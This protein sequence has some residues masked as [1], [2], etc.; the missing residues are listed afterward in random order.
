MERLYIE[1]SKYAAL[2]QNGAFK[3]ELKGSK[4]WENLMA[5]FAGESQ[6]HS[7][8]KYFAAKAKKDGY[9]QIAAIFDETA[10]NEIQHAKIWYKLLNGE[11]GETQGNL[12]LAADGE[13]YEWTDMYTEFAK[14]AKEEGFDHIAFLFEQ[15]ISLWARM[16]LR[17][18]PYV[19]TLK[20]IFR[21]NRVIIDRIKGLL[22]EVIW[23]CYIKRAC[24]KSC[25]HAV[26]FYKCKKFISKCTQVH[27][28]MIQW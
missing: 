21:L 12:K 24:S 4:T 22:C 8:Y 1:K 5:A 13:N 11:I 15:V 14:T 6:A 20:A 3:M 16:H 10:E 2:R 18:V 17:Y 26:F 9:E 23:C 28:F 27:F 25:V 19:H 7:K